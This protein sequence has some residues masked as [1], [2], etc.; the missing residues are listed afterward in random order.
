MCSGRRNI[1][2]IENYFVTTC[3]EDGE[4]SVLDAPDK[5]HPQAQCLLLADLLLVRAEQE[6][7][8][9]RMQSRHLLLHQQQQPS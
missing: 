8:A 2:S 5:K 6:D 3:N 1:K 9:E 7:D 4:E